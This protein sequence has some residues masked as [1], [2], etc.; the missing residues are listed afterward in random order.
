MLHPVFSRAL[1][2]ILLLA[3]VACH[4]ASVT[5]Q[6]G[7]KPLCIVTQYTANQD[8]FAHLAVN[9]HRA[10][11]RAHDYHAIAFRGRISGE[12][13]RDP[14]HPEDS[15]RGGGWYWQKL[16]ATQLVLEQDDA[17]GQNM[18]DWVMWV[19][20]DILFTNF[21]KSLE[22]EI[23]RYVSEGTDVILARE[24]AN[25]PGVL[26]NTG[27]FFVRNT[28]KGRNFL[29]HVAERYPGYKDGALP[30]QDAIQ[31]YA[32]GVNAHTLDRT[33]W[34]ALQYSRRPEVSIAPQ[35]AFNSFARDGEM[36]AAA[37]WQPCDL[38]AHLAGVSASRRAGRMLEINAT[39]R[40]CT[41]GQ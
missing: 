24:E 35:R 13:F 38:V 31:D 11:A 3:S 1:S 6:P 5:H 32:L 16:A 36:P 41:L 30:D 20:A 23:A 18:C 19:D 29:A 17:L 28:D 25:F 21:N 15:L 22:A 26:I 8:S 10:Y 4:D 7:T 37:Q 2:L 12:R 40:K 27:A 33:D 9:N 34:D 14:A 39:I